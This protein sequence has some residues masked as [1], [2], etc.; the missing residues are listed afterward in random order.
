[1]FSAAAES[2]L[3]QAR[4]A[5]P[6][7]L[8]RFAARVAAQ[9]QGPE[10]GP[11]AAACLQRLHLVVAASKYPRRSVRASAALWR[12]GVSEFGVCSLPAAT[13]CPRP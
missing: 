12:W 8:Q 3:R 13:S 11:E 9:L 4:E 6:E 10:P 1:M 7:E 2:F 5:Q